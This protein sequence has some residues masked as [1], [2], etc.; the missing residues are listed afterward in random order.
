V[1]GREDAVAVSASERIALTLCAL[2]ILSEF[3]FGYVGYFAVNAI[4]PNFYFTPIPAGK[5]V[6][7]GLPGGCITVSVTGVI[8]AYRGID[9]LMRRQIGVVANPTSA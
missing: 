5:N 1:L 8:L 7:L 2:G 4:W 3:V 6:W 9:R